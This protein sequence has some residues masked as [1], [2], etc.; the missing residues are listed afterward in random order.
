MA[1]DPL[2]EYSSSTA[3]LVS[4]VDAS[5][6]IRHISEVER[7]LGSRCIPR[8]GMSARWSCVWEV[9]DV[10]ADASKSFERLELSERM[11]GLL[12]PGSQ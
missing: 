3:E 9:F 7:G 6:K 12:S 10:K 1:H 5:G 4:G 11:L 2:L 8:T